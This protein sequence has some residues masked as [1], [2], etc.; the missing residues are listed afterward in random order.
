MVRSAVL[1]ALIA[2]PELG[3]YPLD[4]SVNGKG[5]VELNGTLPTKQD[6]DRATRVVKHVAGVHGVDNAIAVNPIAPALAGA[7][8]APAGRAEPAATAQ[9]ARN[10]D[11]G[12]AIV[13]A[14]AA[15]PALR[16]VQVSVSAAAVV[17]SGQ[18]STRQAKDQAGAIAQHSADG[19]KVDNRIQVKG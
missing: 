5:R 2:D 17:L 6:K 14:L 15:K 3:P 7:A 10:A 9:A 11:I 18:V 4:A 12:T 19:R 1:Q 16:G 8:A 13:N